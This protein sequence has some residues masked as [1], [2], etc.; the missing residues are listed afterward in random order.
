MSTPSM[1]PE[2][3]GN[4]VI[5]HRLRAGYFLQKGREF[6]ADGDLHQASEKGWAAAAHIVKAAATAYGWS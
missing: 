4:A 6:L 3:T 2:E 5:D 1:E